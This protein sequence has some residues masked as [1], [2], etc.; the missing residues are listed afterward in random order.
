MALDR[1][2]A[3]D[4]FEFWGI[5]FQLDGEGGLRCVVESSWRL[6]N[7]TEERAHMDLAEAEAA[8]R[9]LPGSSERFAGLVSGRS[10]RI[11]LVEDY[12]QGAILLCRRADGVPSWAD[13]R[14]RPSA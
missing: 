14:A 10:V 11:E 12:G 1:F 3:G 13:L 5:G 6:Q 2:E 9:A 4:S 8:L 7:L